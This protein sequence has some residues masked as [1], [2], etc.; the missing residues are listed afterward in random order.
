MGQ[1]VKSRI[2][3]IDHDLNAIISSL[4]MSNRDPFQ[5]LPRQMY[6]LFNLVD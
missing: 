1:Y 6:L 5:Y 4:F 3:F 2:Y